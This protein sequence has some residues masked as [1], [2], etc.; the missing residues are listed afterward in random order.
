M[1]HGTRILSAAAA[2]AGARSSGR[3]CGQ[4]GFTLIEILV[5]VAI[6]ALLVAILLPSLARARE[7]SRRT[8][9]GSNLLQIHKA[10][11]FYLADWKG[12][13]PPH[14][15]SINVA[16]GETG[17]DESKQKFWYYLFERYTKTRAV[18]HCP[19]LANQ[20]QKANAKNNVTWEWNFDRANLGYGYNAFFLGLHSWP[21]GER[22]GTY[23]TSHTWF[24][25]S[26]V[27]H[28]SWCLIFADSDPN[29]DPSSTKWDWGASLWWPSIIIVGGGVNK[30][31]DGVEEDRH[32]KGA[33]VAFVDGHVEFR[34]EGMT[35]P[36]AG[37]P[38]DDRI[39]IWDPLIRRK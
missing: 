17:G 10:D 27:K 3:R 4:R 20:T 23:I 24:K 33:N 11:T 22:Y 5:V 21:D 2:S 35:N 31:D 1:R 8:V 37:Y 14:K 18:P 15:Y 26:H 25:E 6:I 19:T 30:Y 38:D 29:G 32:L 34:R 7:A 28:P 36:R 16:A 12:V 39:H 9:C 13:F